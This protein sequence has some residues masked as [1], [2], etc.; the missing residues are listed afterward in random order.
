MRGSERE[1]PAMFSYVALEDRIPTEHPLRT[2]RPIV[3]RALATL[4]PT[5]DQIYG[6]GGR[7]SIPPEQL[8]R[9]LLLQ[10]LYTIR[11]ERQLMEQLEY[12]LLYRWFVGL[13][14][15]DPVW[16]VTVFTKN[17]QRLLIGDVA[18]GFFAA[19][20]GEARQAHLLSSEHFTVDGTLVQAWAGQKSFQRDPDKRDPDDPSGGLPQVPKHRRKFLAGDDPRRVPAE[21]GRNPTVNFQGERRSNQTHTSTTD[22][23][24]LLMKKAK[25]QEAVLAYQA[26]LLMENRNGLAVGVCTT[27]ATGTAERTNAVTLVQQTPYRQ[28]CITVGGD[29]GFDTVEC[30]ASLRAAG[31]TPHV[32]QW[33]TDRHPSAIDARTTRQPGYELSQRKRKRIE[34][35]FGWLKTVGL[36][37]QTKFRGVDRVGWMVTF[38]TAAYN[39]VR[40]RNLLRPT[41]A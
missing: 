11:S 9:A 25:G 8:L 2:V 5:F 33:I 22:P 23:D 3:N 28:E 19:V 21:T 26:T 16:D 6:D 37:R 7:P 30:V 13:G 41:P 4:S 14:V 17:R 12:N 24:A 29:K 32:A 27:P 40:I 39:L 31:C 10:V 35:I 1:Q 34:E 15:D 38:A 20:L 18:D 36:C